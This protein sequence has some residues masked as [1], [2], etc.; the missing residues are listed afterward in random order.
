MRGIMKQIELLQL[1]KLNTIGLFCMIMLDD[2]MKVKGK[3]NEMV[4]QDIAE[5]IAERL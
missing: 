3:E 5:I 2:A 4:V 1:I